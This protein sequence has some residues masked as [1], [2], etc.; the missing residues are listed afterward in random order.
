MI[1]AVS[2]LIHCIGWGPDSHRKKCAQAVEILARDYRTKRCEECR[3]LHRKWCER[4]HRALKHDGRQAA[5]T[6]ARARIIG[7]MLG[8]GGIA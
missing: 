3:K 2:R 6:D 7:W 8:K 1:V 5:V 4:K